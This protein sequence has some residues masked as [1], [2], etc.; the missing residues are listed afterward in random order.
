MKVMSRAAADVAWAVGFTSALNRA[1]RYLRVMGRCYS[2][3]RD[4]SAGSYQVLMYHRVNP[5]VDPFSVATVHPADFERQIVFLKQHYNVLPL[6][7]LWRRVQ[8][9]TLPPNAVA[10]TFDDGYADNHDVA[11]PILRKHQVPATLFLTSS[12]AEEGGP[13][14]HDKVL[15]AFRTTRCQWLEFEP[16]GLPPTRLDNVKQR[17]VIAR[18]CLAGLRAL[19]EPQRRR[20]LEELLTVLQVRDFDGLRGLMLSWDDARALERGGFAVEDHTATHPVL[21]RLS[22]QAARAEVMGSKR[23]I[24]ARLQKEVRFFAY[25]NGKRDDFTPATQ[26]MLRQ[27]GFACAFS[28]VPTKNLIG[29]DAFALG[30]VTP[31]FNDV[32]RFALLQARINLAG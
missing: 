4:S 18:R 14:W 10:L 2:V 29:D 15:H 6:A 20:C 12:V 16:L 17:P 8:E 7:E 5:K 31:W 22:P 21:S 3:L 24:E 27:L 11:L 23:L 25:P 28:T 13:L 32:A 1:T 30:R 19:P 26:A 9:H